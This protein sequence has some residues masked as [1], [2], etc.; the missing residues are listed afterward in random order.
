MDYTAPPSV[1]MELPQG[2]AGTRRTL[3]LMVAMARQGKTDPLVRQTAVNLT[4]NLK[5]KDWNAEVAALH[6]F[7]RDKIRYLRDVRGVETLQTANYTLRNRSGDC[8]D[9][10][11]LLAALLES[12]THPAR[13]VAVGF[14]DSGSCDHVFV[15]TRVGNR[16]PWMALETTEPVPP[17]WSPLANG[18]AQK[19]IIMEI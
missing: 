9:K 1:L 2:I 8:D 19:T 4:N 3:A 18:N 15:E 10:S 7:V 13:F 6:A 14:R 11:V 5:Q 17:G 12:I 16:G